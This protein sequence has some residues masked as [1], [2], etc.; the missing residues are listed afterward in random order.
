MP[1]LLLRPTSKGRGTGREGR[2]GRGEEGK[3]APPSSQIP[4][5]APVVCVLKLA[6]LQSVPNITSSEGF[7]VAWVSECDIVVSISLNLRYSDVS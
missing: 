4:G 5:P 1:K 2:T 6:A 3:V 7:V